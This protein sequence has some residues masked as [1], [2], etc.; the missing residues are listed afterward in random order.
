MIDLMLA[1]YITQ[2]P[3]KKPTGGLMIDIPRTRR[4]PKKPIELPK[5]SGFK[6]RITKLYENGASTGLRWEEN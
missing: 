4:F 3:T 6:V 2:V 1:L 5:K